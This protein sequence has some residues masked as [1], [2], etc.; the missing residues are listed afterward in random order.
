MNSDSTIQKSPERAKRSESTPDP[1]SPG[2]VR[3]TRGAIPAYR[4]K[5]PKIKSN[6][7]DTGAAIANVYGP[8]SSS[9]TAQETEAPLE[10][11]RAAS[12]DARD[13]PA[14]AAASSAAVGKERDACA[15]VAQAPKGKI[16]RHSGTNS[17][18]GT[19]T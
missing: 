5:T 11:S 19:G 18:T 7:H 2:K 14:A 16:S 15:E 8:A 12:D 10:K 1:G 4:R 17:H 9:R 6:G 3:R 13:F